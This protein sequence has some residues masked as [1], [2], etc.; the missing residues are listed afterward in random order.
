MKIVSQDKFN[1]T[2]NCFDKA[3]GNKNLWIRDDLQVRKKACRFVR[4]LS[5]ILR[6][7]GIDCYRHYRVHNVAYQIFV[8]AQTNKDHLTV[9]NAELLIKTLDYLKGRTGKKY[10]L[11]V[12]KTK[13]AIQGLLYVKNADGKP[14]ED[15]PEKTEDEATLVV[16]KDEPEPEKK[17]Q[18]K[19]KIHRPLPPLPVD[20][21]LPATAPPPPPPIAVSALTPVAAR[22]IRTTSVIGAGE[23][24]DQKNN[25][26]RVGQVPSSNPVPTDNTMFDRVKELSSSLE[27]APAGESLNANDSMWNPKHKNFVAEKNRDIKQAQAEKDEQER[28]SREQIESDRPLA[29]N[30][31]TVNEEL[32]RVNSVDV[33]SGVTFSPEVL[34]ALHKDATNVIIGRRSAFVSVVGVDDWS[35]EENNDLIDG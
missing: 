29:K 16:V 5:L 6:I 26:K 23:L 17:K 28:R 33:T 15:T 13:A 19:G 1:E 31:N 20:V 12:E 27:D 30:S 4:V 9:D 2:I 25:L 22:D 8:F 18:V 3:V 35:D 10:G 7:I 32:R 11:T 21:P 34:E 14:L 24:K